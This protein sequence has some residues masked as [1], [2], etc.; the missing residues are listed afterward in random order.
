MSLLSCF[1]IKE[2]SF[3]GTLVLNRFNLI[4]GTCNL[5]KYVKVLVA[6][7]RQQACAHL[8]NCYYYCTVKKSP[9]RQSISAILNT[10]TH[11]ELLVQVV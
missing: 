9:R 4:N 10:Q 11:L 3:D 5:T 1:V 2:E 6:E 8:D 7:C